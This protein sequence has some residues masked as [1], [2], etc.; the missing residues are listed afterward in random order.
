MIH[1]PTNS[2]FVYPPFISLHNYFPNRIQVKPQHRRRYNLL[3]P[4]VLQTSHLIKMV[5]NPSFEGRLVVAVCQ[6][7]N[8]IGLNG[9]LPWPNL[10]A[11]MNRFKQLTT[12]SVVIMGSATYFSI[13]PSYRPLPSR[14]NIVLSSRSRIQLE[15]PD[16]VFLAGSL[17]A[18]ID[19]ALSRGHAFAYIIGGESV[20][21]E[22]L[23]N[24]QWSHRIYFTDISTQFETDRVF[25]VNLNDKNNGFELVSM[26]KDY[27]QAGAH[28]CFKEYVRVSTSDAV[29]QPL[30]QP[31]HEEHQY[32]DLVRR[33][34]DTGI[35]KGDRTGT[36]TLSLFGAQMRF[37]LRDS[38]PL[39][40]TKR[41]FWR[42]VAEE[43][44][45]FIHG[46]TDA[47]KLKEKDIHIWDG[48]SSREFLDSR[49]FTARQVGDLGPVY[50]F[51]WRH[52]GAEYKDMGTDYKGKGVDQLKQ[53]IDTIKRNPN[54]RRMLMSAW[55]P[56]AVHEMAL[57]PCHLLAQFYVANGEL[58]CQMYQRSC[59]MGLGVPFNIA[60]YALLTCLIAKVTGLK[61]G[62]F[63]H[64]LGDAHVYLNHTDA[65]REQL[66]REPRRFPQLEIRH[67]ENIEDFCF[68][69][70]KLIGY[71]PHKSI[72]MKMAV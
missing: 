22:A 5:S 7:N 70:L 62:E 13:P 29:P 66:Q 47:N 36:G 21:K 30:M 17:S 9:K 50:G 32:L 64:T 56:A 40:T 57:P 61:A 33:I 51:Q 52:F 44:F 45:W 42:G 20:F 49:G 67:K 69:D 18:A 43:L 14:L 2:S 6:P 54:D 1:D 60:S 4:K 68:D 55:N 48:N 38:F 59:D 16:S 63:V 39:L 53:V 35:R 11:D 28:F 65:L 8:G 46:S 58:S 31:V 27:D 25:P 3:V 26:S 19:L 15:L 12:N 41:V 10:S 24:P 71:N 37:S 23:T 34:L 72:V